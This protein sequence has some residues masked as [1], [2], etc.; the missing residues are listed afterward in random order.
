MANV[1][2]L[3]IAKPD[4][5]AFFDDSDSRLYKRS[6]IASILAV[7]RSFWRLAQRTTLNE[8]IEF[9]T[10]KISLQKLTLKATHHSEQI[11]RYVWGDGGCPVPC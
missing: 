11:I 10:S 5:A 8:F 4:I 9:L 2:R 3:Q 1:S 7:Q 6:D